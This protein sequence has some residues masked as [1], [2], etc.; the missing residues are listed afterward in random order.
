M[1]L[2]KLK[3]YYYLDNFAVQIQKTH[4]LGMQTKQKEKIGTTNLGTDI[5]IYHFLN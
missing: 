3:Y 1:N 2:R 4:Q 5:Q